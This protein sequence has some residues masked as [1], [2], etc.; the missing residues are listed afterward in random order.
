MRLLKILSVTSF[1][2]ISGLGQHA[3]PNFVMIPFSLEQFLQSIATKHGDQIW[4]DLA[5]Y[6][7]G[8]IFCICIIAFSRKYKDRYM[9]LASLVILLVVEIYTSEIFHHN[10]LIFWFI[11]PFLIFFITSSLLVL[12]NFRAKEESVS[13]MGTQ[14]I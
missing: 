7:I 9:L 11:F 5:V 14:G 3:I 6:S 13:N 4:W 8:V 1:L 10:K 2:L 12:K